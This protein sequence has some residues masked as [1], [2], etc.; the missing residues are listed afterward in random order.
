MAPEE[1]VGRVDVIFT[2][3]CLQYVFLKLCSVENDLFA[4]SQTEKVSLD[5]KSVGSFIFAAFVSVFVV[6]YTAHSSL[7]ENLVNLRFRVSRGAGM[8]KCSYVG[9]SFC[10]TKTFYS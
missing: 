4:H 3:L 2:F 10:K 7:E 6:L 5:R 8:K 1:L 9:P